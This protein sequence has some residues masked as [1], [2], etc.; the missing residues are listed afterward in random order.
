MQLPTTYI[1]VKVR[2]VSQTRLR[3]LYADQSRIHFIATR[4]CLCFEKAASP[5]FWCAQCGGRWRRRARPPTDLELS[6]SLRPQLTELCNVHNQAI[7]E[8]DRPGQAR[9]YKKAFVSVC[10][11][12]KLHPSSSVST[13]V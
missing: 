4:P 12:T 9:V 8:A 13:R 6:S 5:F 3:Y 11:F 2:A 7:L 1:P 10:F